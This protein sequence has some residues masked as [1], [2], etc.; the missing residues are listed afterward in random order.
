MSCAICNAAQEAMFYLHLNPTQLRTSLRG[1]GDSLISVRD[2]VGRD[3]SKVQ[4]PDSVLCSQPPT[5]LITSAEMDQVIGVLGMSVGLEK[6]APV[7]KGQV[8]SSLSPLLPVFLWGLSEHNSQRLYV[9][10]DSRLI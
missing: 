9:K 6:E 7:P 8:A 4:N 2:D 1:Q 10:H 3:W 5:P